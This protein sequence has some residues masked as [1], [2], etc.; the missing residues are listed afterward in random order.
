[1]KNELNKKNKIN[2]FIFIVFIRSSPETYARNVTKTR[3]IVELKTK[4]LKYTRTECY[5]S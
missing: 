3:R 4:I 2:E 5:Q 1:M